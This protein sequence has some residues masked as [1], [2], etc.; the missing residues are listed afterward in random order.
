MKYCSHCKIEVDTERKTC[1]LCFH[2]LDE[3]E[4]ST[5]QPYKPYE[6][7]SRSQ[8][9][10]MRIV[11]Y[12]VIVSIIASTI[13]NIATLGKNHGVRWWS[14]MVDVSAIYTYFFITTMC[15][16][17]RNMAVRFLLQIFLL[18]ILVIVINLVTNPE[19][20][21]SLTYVI[22]FCITSAL[23]TT[24]MMTF[25]RNSLYK[26]YLPSMVLM[27]LL[28]AIPIILYFTTT[29]MSALWPSIVSVSIG[30]LV[31][32]GIFIFPRRVTQEEI[33]KR[34]HL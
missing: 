30:F 6:R 33:K 25:I 27:S 10:F 29:W 16:G 34:F 11:L 4:P 13:V 22:P 3:K 14:L 26:E 24:V 23:I 32:L 31:L 20:L 17:R 5:Y 19:I 28:S 21:W 18:S 8:E 15:K 9:I 2:L 7:P 12:I 1:P